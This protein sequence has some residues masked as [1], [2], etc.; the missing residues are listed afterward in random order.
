MY[1]RNGTEKNN[2]EVGMEWET[3]KMTSKWE[4]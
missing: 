2:S 4:V 3:I 1:D